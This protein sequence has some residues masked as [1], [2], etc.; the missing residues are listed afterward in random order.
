MQEH[1]SH[2]HITAE[3]EKQARFYCTHCKHELASSQ[4]V[5]QKSVVSGNLETQESQNKVRKQQAREDKSIDLLTER[6]SNLRVSW[7]S[8]HA[9]S[10]TLFFTFFVYF[11]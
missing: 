4:Y 7:F 8:L 9:I 3:G 1:V 6:E 11:L 10:E 5:I 2:Y